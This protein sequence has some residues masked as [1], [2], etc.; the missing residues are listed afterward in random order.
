ME[1]GIVEVVSEGKTHKL[2]VTLD[3]NV[4]LRQGTTLSDEVV[5]QIIDGGKDNVGDAFT[6]DGV[7]YVVTISQWSAA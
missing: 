6:V 1:F 3:E 5:Y 7:V 2:F 4:V